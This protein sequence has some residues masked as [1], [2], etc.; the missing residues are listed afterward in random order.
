MWILDF[1]IGTATGILSGFGIGG[2]T[3][4]ILW[5]TLFAGMQQFQAGGINLL[6]FPFAAVPALISHVKHKLVD[7]KVVLWCV[8]AGI[9]LCISS[10]V[11]AANIDVPFLKKAFGVLLL[12]IGFKELFVKRSKDNDTTDKSPKQT[13]KA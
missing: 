10:S 12:F 11:V 1:I 4:L 13:E 3:L 9:P 7:K 2:G 8:A 5:L 6:Y